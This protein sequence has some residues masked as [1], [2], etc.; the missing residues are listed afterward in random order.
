MI[1][2]F[3]FPR[4]NR[5]AGEDFKSGLYYLSPMEILNEVGTV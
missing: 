1:I 4:F 2:L 5:R 3:F